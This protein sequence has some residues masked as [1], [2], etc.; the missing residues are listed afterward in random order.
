VQAGADPDFVGPAAYSVLGTL[1]KKR[2][3][4]YEYES[5]YLFT[6]R[7]EITTNYK[8]K[9]LTNSTNITIFNKIT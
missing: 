9:K 4:S 5:A 2:I 6:T 3:Q 8:F 1:Y 7:N